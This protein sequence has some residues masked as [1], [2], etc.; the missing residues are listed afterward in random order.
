MENNE[1]FVVLFQAPKVEPLEYRLYYGDQGEVLCYT[2]DKNADIQGNYV[3]IDRMTFAEMRFDV[4]VIDGQV[5]RITPNAIVSKLMPNNIEGTSCHPS[6]IS[7]IVDE[8]YDGE[9]L[10][11]KQVSYELK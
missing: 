2:C 7:I 6:D 8:S 3:V 9:I 5:S 1:E 10:K 11:W 4:R